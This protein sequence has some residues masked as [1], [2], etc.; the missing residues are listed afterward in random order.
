MVST[1]DA[2]FDII[3]ATDSTA[4]LRMQLDE[5]AYLDYVYKLRS[6]DYRVDFT[7]RGHELRRFLP[8]NIA[9]QDIEWRQ[10]IPQQEQSWKFEGQYSGIYYHYPQGDVDRLERPAK[11][12]KISKRRCAGWPSRTS[13]SAPY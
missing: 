7:I 6:S 12:T 2:N 3:E 5:S 1:A 10:R 4:T 9:L 8:V 13:T 11:P